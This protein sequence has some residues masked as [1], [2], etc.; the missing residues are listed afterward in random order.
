MTV[1]AIGNASG[2]DESL[3]TLLEQ[4]KFDAQNDILWFSGNHFQI[5][6]PS[7]S[8]IRFIKSLGKAAISVLGDE[9][10]HLLAMA[11]GY[12][13][14]DTEG[15][16]NQISNEPDF[17][18]LI[19]WLRQRPL[20][21]YDKNQNFALVHAGIPPEWTLSQARTFAIEVES[22]L[23]FGN[24]KTFLEHISSKAVPRRWNA[25]LHG[26]K[27]LHF[28]SHAFTRIQNCTEKGYMDFG[29]KI[30]SSSQ[31]DLYQP[32]YQIAVRNTAGVK[33]IFGQKQPSATEQYPNIFPLEYTSGRSLTALN[34]DTPTETITVS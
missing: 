2:N 9:D 18:E 5:E 24:H 8:L 27:R 22:A 30:D 16:I 21:H 14:K 25:K 11:E 4:I 15:D 19:K 33:I 6:N 23:S 7:L 10:L 1:Y 29:I 32:W 26:W 28:I 13:P 31:D 3:Q 12:M 20:L 17:A 34:L